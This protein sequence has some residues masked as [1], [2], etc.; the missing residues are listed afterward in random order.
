MRQQGHNISLAD[1]GF[2]ALKAV[3]AQRFDLILMDVRMQDMDGP[4][5]A[6]IVNHILESE[7]SQRYSGDTGPLPVK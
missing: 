5:A 2:S 3:L 7:G 4:V 6:K 1:S